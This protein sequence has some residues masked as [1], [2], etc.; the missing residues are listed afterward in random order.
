[1]SKIYFRRSSPGMKRLYDHIAGVYKHVSG[2]MEEILDIVIDKKISKIPDI[3]SSTA[4]EYACGTGSLSLKLSRLFKTVSSR[5]F[6][7]KMLDIARERAGSSFKN[8]VFSEGDILNIDED[9]K[10]YDY[11]FISFALH[12]FPRETEV[13]IIRNLCKVARKGVYIID[14]QRKWTLSEAIVEWIEG[15]YYDEFI[16][17]DFNTMANQA[18]CRSFTE[19]PFKNCTLFTFV[20]Q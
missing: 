7:S 18:G 3:S 11:A 17:Y 8:L 10:S 16:R 9:D 4:L 12:L 20:P 19:E 2:G 14:H 13:S 1:M 6:S 5:D 15:G